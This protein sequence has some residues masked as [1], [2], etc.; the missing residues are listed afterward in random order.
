MPAPF[1]IPHTRQVVVV[2]TSAN[3]KSADSADFVFAE[4]GGFELPVPCGTPVFKTGALNHYATP[5]C[6]CVGLLEECTTRWVYFQRFMVP[7]GYMQYMGVDYGTKRVGIAIS[8]EEGSFAFPKEIVA[9]SEAV[10]FIKALC[11]M[12]PIGAV[13]IGE[14]LATNGEENDVVIMAKSFAKKL[15]SSISVPIFF[16]REGFSS[17]EAHRYQTKKGN[18]DD[19]AAAVILQRF[20]DKQKK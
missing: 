16:E 17:V 5:P 20:L 13:V 11:E 3:T 7:L 10:S 9:T 14:S 6:V 2:F 15:E 19:S 1:E 4:V 18:R 12:S 8:D